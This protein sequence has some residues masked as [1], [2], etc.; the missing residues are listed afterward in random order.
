MQKGVKQTIT[1]NKTNKQKKNLIS[2]NHQEVLLFKENPQREMYMY[3][4]FSQGAI[5]RRLHVKRKVR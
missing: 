5:W 2:K 4:I 3:I 1:T